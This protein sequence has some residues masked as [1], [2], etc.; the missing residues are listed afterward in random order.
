M[1]GG[2]RRGTAIGLESGQL[3]RGGNSW[4]DDKEARR[5]QMWFPGGLGRR[6]HRKCE[7]GKQE[8]GHGHPE[9]HSD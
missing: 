8:S 6:G 9:P 1:L 4:C 3:D 7:K 5:S 2:Q